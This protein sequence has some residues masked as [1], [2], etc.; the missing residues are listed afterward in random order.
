MKNQSPSQRVISYQEALRLRAEAR[1]AGDR[2]VLTNGCFDIL[3]R[4]HLEYLHSSAALGDLLIVAI[5]SDASVRSLKGPSRPVHRE[6][7]RA[8]AV[9]SLRF[10]DAV[11]I[12]EGP[13]LN[14]EIANLAPDIYT[15][16]GD[17]TPETLEKSEVN[18]LRS[19]GAEIHILPFLGGHS[20]TNI[21]EKVS[22]GVPL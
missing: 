2:V 3:H 5:N 1:S 10:V 13:R 18:A 6:Q 21:I 8:F 15:K 7:D 14:N 9:A 20:T 19:V 22:S 12:F 4:G 16:A 17:Y 11:F